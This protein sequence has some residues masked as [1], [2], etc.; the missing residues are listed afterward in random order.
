M[1]NL[2]DVA[3]GYAFIDKYIVTND[4]ESLGISL[5]QGRQPEKLGEIAI[6]K[7]KLIYFNAVGGYRDKDT[8]EIVA[9]DCC[10]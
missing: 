5:I 2:Q 6:P 10:H 3:Y 4:I 7:S 9:V 8:Y 1:V